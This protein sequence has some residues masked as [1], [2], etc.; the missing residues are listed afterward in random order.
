MIILENI[1]NVDYM[2]MSKMFKSLFFIFRKMFIGGLSWQTTPG[3]ESSAW[4]I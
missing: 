3:T 2:F 4:S 1:L